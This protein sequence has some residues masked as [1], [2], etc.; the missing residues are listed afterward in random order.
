[1]TLMALLAIGD[2]GA[3]NVASA[4]KVI[5]FPQRTQLAPQRTQLAPERTQRAYREDRT[6]YGPYDRSRYDHSPYDYSPYD[7]NAYDRPYGGGWTYYYGR[8]YFYAPAPFP[9]GFD[10]G[11]GW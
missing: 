6:G 3:I 5:T 8:P 1:M 9:L 4:A 10:F 11:F 7:Y 2:A